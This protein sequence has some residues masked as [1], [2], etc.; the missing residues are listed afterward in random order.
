MKRQNFLSNIPTN[1]SQEI[2]ETII[3]SEH[4]RIERIIS[5][6][7]SSPENFWYDQLENEWVL[8]L[9]GKAMIKFDDESVITLHKGDYILI[10]AHQKHR[11][12]WSDPEHRTI[13][14]TI[15]FK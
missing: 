3:S 13:W 14:L 10:P 5:M 11:V 8:L 4:I 2:I 15:F 12:E 1:I 9:E 7:H 6:G